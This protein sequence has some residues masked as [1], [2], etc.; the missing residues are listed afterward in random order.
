MLLR[1]E[2]GEGA[3]DRYTI[4]S[5]WLLEELRH[6]YA[7]CRLRTWLFPSRRDPCRPM[8]EACPL[9]DTCRHARRLA[10]EGRLK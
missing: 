10:T 7:R 9:E 2:Q 5:P 8:I 1:I 4:L 3:K 6:Y